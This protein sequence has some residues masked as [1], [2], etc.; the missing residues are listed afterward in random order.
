MNGRNPKRYGSLGS[1]SAAADVTQ[2]GTLDM[3]RPEEGRRAGEAVAC[4]IADSLLALRAWRLEDPAPALPIH[5]RLQTVS[6]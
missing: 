4:A 5:E 2:I 6:A 3:T 1:C